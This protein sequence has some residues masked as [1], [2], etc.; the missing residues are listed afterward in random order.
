LQQVY[1]FTEIIRQGR[2]SGRMPRL[3]SEILYDAIVQ[4]R[5]D[6]VWEDLSLPGGRSSVSFG[7]SLLISTRTKHASILR[8]LSKVS[9][10]RTRR[11]N[12]R[13]AVTA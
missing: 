11:A 4:T 9:S 1:V 6:P 10:R 5:F 2:A 3:A 7:I 13:A 8:G 12:F